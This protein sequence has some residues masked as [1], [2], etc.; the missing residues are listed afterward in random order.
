V[1][2]IGIVTSWLISNWNII[3][4]EA[5]ASLIV[6]GIFFGISYV[7]KKA[8][9]GT[10]LRTAI[11]LI[12]IFLGIFLV[13]T[14]AQLWNSTFQISKA[15]NPSFIWNSLIASVGMIVLYI[16]GI[17]L[18]I[19][20]GLIINREKAMVVIQAFYEHFKRSGMYDSS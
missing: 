17:L 4:D 16:V 15:T 6:A 3:L 13:I 2:L 20:G 1:D 11:G 10:V 19:W 8:T 18:V 12:I 9:K 7:R 14:G 5:I